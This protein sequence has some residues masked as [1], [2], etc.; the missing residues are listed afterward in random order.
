MPGHPDNSVTAFYGYG[1]QVVGRVGTAH[2]DDAKEFNVFR[3]RTSDAP[4][5]GSGLEIAKT[6]SRYVHRADAGT[7][8]D[9]GSRAGPRRDA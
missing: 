9:G 6:G 3:L 4:W 5:F 7:S 2:D 8:P 1:R